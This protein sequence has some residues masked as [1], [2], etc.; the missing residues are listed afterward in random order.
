M[1]SS[2]RKPR[3]PRKPRIRETRWVR[4]CARC[5]RLLIFLMDPNNPR[6]TKPCLLADREGRMVWNGNPFWRPGIDQVHVDYEY[7]KGRQRQPCDDFYL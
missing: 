3:A 7:V 2:P 5:P 4:R 6:I 1:V